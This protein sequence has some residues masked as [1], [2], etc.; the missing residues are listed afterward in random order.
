[1]IKILQRASKKFKKEKLQDKRE[2]SSRF[3]FNDKSQAGC[4]KYENI[5]RMIKNYAL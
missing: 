4:F 1:M 3:C 5:D 2:I